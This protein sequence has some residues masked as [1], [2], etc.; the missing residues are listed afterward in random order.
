MGWTRG[1]GPALRDTGRD[2]ANGAGHAGGDRRRA[3]G[4]EAELLA[5]LGLAGELLLAELVDEVVAVGV[6]ERHG[7][8]LVCQDSLSGRHI[9]T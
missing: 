8:H 3:E 9:G 6:E 4:I 1:R 7:L 5:A 2:G